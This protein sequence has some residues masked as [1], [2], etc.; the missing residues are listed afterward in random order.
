MKPMSPQEIEQA[1]G[2]L[3]IIG[4][5]FTPPDNA[6]SIFGPSDATGGAYTDPTATPEYPG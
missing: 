3:D 6:Q 4:Y 2:G 5:P 1:C